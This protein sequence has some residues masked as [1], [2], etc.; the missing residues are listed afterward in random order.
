[1]ARWKQFRRAGACDIVF[2]QKRLMS[3]LW[4]GLLRKHARRLVYEYDDAVFLT[5][6]ADK[7]I[8]SRFRLARFARV[9]Q[10]ADAVVTSNDYLASYARK[11]TDQARIAILPNCLDLARWPRKHVRPRPSSITIGWIGS[12]SNLQYLAPMR[13]GLQKICRAFPEV[14]LKVVCDRP[15][16]MEGVRIV[17]KAFT[18]DDEVN[19]VLSFDI[20]VACY[21]DDAWTMGKSPVKV[22]SY[23]AA[24]LPVV[25]SD[26]TCVRRFIADRVNGLLVAKPEDWEQKIGVL[27][28]SWELCI[29]LGNEARKTVEEQYNVERVVDRYVSLFNNLK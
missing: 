25:A 21:P 17:N 22:L 24:G 5:R 4:V 7:V 15:L 13:H 10:H 29:E 2:L 20:A 16:E 27:I 14:T 28:D 19:D 18:E 1:M 3:R 26:V 8:T 12:G 11:Y 23:M 6:K 9:V